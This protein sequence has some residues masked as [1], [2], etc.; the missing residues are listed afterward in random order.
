MPP[1]H[2]TGGRARRGRNHRTTAQVPI[3]ALSPTNQQDSMNHGDVLTAMNHRLFQRYQR[4][5]GDWS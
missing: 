2:V 1:E 4:E 3:I 5:A